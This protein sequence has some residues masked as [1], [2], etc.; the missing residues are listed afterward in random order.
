MATVAAE[1]TTVVA[2]MVTAAEIPAEEV[3]MAAVM[4]EAEAMMR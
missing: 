1:M 3:T 4:T 2:V